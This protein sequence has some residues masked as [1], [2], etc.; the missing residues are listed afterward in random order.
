MKLSLSPGRQRLLI[1][2]AVLALWPLVLRDAGAQA[3]LDALWRGV[4]VTVRVTLLSFVL[5]LGLGLLAGLGRVSR[6]TSIQTLSS[7]Y[8]ELVRGLPML[9]LLLW[10]GYA[11]APSL[12]HLAMDGLRAL[13]DRG[14][15]LAGLGPLILETCRRP[16]D[17]LSMELRGIL[18]LAFGYGAY[19]AE[20]VRAGIQSVPVGQAEAAASLGM[21]QGQ[22][23][24]LVILP[25]ALRLAL[26]P[27]GNDFIALLKDSALVSALTVADIVYAARIHV[28][29][30]FEALSVWNMVALLY[31]SLTLL[32][33]LLVGRLE[34]RAGGHT[35]RQPT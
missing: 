1:T 14:I 24:R 9:V 35:G 27:L 31:L 25:Q 22:R 10:F 7:I 13:G 12:F 23:M 32:L 16:A 5:A 4:G 29:R 11:L 28:A 8:V 20:I 33:S 30:T 34:E 26:P 17:C 15:D 6:R 3:T 2:L 18:G 19:I 21:S